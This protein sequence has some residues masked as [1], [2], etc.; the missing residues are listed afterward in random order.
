M[1]SMAGKRIYPQEL[2]VGESGY[3]LNKRGWVLQ[4]TVMEVKVVNGIEEVRFD[5]KLVFM[6]QFRGICE[7]AS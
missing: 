6:P 4:F 2:G 7:A 1:F 3:R 5:M